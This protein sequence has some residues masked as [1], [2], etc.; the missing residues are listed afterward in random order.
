M[1]TT[2]APTHIIDGHMIAS[3]VRVGERTGPDANRVIE[4]HCFADG[5]AMVRLAPIR[6]PDT[7]PTIIDLPAPAGNELLAAFGGTELIS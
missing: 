1:T 4:M 2:M 3:V 7:N 5:S 6:D